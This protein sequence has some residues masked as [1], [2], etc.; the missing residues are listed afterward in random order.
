VPQTAA[1]GSSST[2]RVPQTAARVVEHESDATDHSVRVVEHESGATDHSTRIVGHQVCATEPGQD[3]IVEYESRGE[4]ANHQARIAG[5]GLL[6]GQTAQNNTGACPG[7]AELR[8]VGG[9]TEWPESLHAGL[10]GAGT[11]REVARTA[12]RAKQQI[13]RTRLW[14]SA[15]SASGRTEGEGPEGQGPSGTEVPARSDGPSP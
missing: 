6:G 7:Y 5:Q 14:A 10:G 11:E 2:N 9:G 1:Y 8:I 12:D 4:G 13:R 15:A 3:Q